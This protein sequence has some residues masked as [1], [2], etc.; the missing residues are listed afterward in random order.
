MNL[1]ETEEGQQALASLQLDGFQ[2]ATPALFD[3]IAD[4]MADLEP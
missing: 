2:Q 4:R 1:A 3:G